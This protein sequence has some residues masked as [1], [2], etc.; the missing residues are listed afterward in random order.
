MLSFLPPMGRMRRVGYC[1]LFL[2]VGL[3]ALKVTVDLVRM[4]LLVST[5]PV[6]GDANGYATVARAMLNGFTPY[7]EM[8][9][10]KPPGIFLLL[11]AS[12]ALTG[13]EI[14]ATWAQMATYILFPLLCALFALSVYG[15][16]WRSLRAGILIGAAFIAGTLLVLYTEERGGA[17]EPEGFG[18]FFSMVYAFLLLHTGL[19]SRRSIV[20]ASIMLLCSIGMKEPFLFIN[21]A[22]ALLLTPSWRD[23]PRTFFLPLAIAGAIGALVLLL[24]GLLMPYLTVQLPNMVAFRIQ[25]AGEWNPMWLRPLRTRRVFADLVE[26]NPTGRFTGWLV[27]FLWLSTP[28]LLFREERW[29]PI[30]VATLV[31]VFGSL[32]LSD[33]F[34]FILFIKGNAPQMSIALTSTHYVWIGLTAVAFSAIAILRR[35]FLPWVLVA[36]VVLYLTL[37]T[38]GVGIAYHP[39]FFAFAVPVYGAL[40]LLWLRS[41]ASRDA[42]LL[43]TAGVLTLVILGGALYRQN[44]RHINDFPK[45]TAGNAA[46]SRAYAHRLDVLLD[47]CGIDRYV[48]VGSG[49]REFSFAKHSPWGPVVGVNVHK[50]F[51]ADNPY[52]IQSLRNVTDRARIIIYEEQELSTRPVLLAAWPVIQERYTEEVPDCAKSHLPFYDLH[53]LFRKG[54]FSS[55]LQPSQ[56]L[57]GDATGICH[58]GEGMRLGGQGAKC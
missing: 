44:P 26:F 14:F 51:T 9:L 11:A 5:S 24:L 50:F 45:L 57:F 47:A 55:T 37:F 48:L 15:E 42:P 4:L 56:N 3:V 41:A 6:N 1:I 10:T 30:V 31:A 38:I 32:F 20:A 40:L 2:V 58:D 19:R 21:L 23:L 43:V 52:V 13:S 46:A 7:V 12:L 16:R 29:W 36:L 54:S 28:L 34:Y 27:V 35:A 8:E 33:L 53:V 49:G 39:N 17:L 25:D 18:Y 22:I